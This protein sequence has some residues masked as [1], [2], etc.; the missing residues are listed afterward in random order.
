L[1]SIRRQLI[2]NLSKRRKCCCDW[3][4]GLAHVVQLLVAY[5]VAVAQTWKELDVLS[6]PAYT[7]KQKGAYKM[8]NRKGCGM[9][10]QWPNFRFVWK[11][12]QKLRKTSVGT[13]GAAVGIQT[14]YP[15]PE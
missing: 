8:T 3:S 7:F 9:K 15:P 4:G 11:Y 12:R 2:N 1:L 10:Q 6:K 14:E 13:A 5:A